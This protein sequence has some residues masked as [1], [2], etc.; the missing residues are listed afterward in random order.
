MAA[1]WRHARNLGNAGMFFGLG[2]MALTLSSA[3]YVGVTGYPCNPN[4][5]IAAAN[6]NNPCNQNNMLYRNPQPTD[7]APLLG[8]LGASTSA[9]GFI[10][11]ASSLGYQHHLLHKLDADPG[12]GVF[13][14]GTVFGVLGFVAVGV[15]YFI[16]LT[17]YLG[18]RDQALAILGTSITS[19][20]FSALGSLLYMI[21]SQRTKRAWNRL[22]TSY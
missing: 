9:L 7:P 13:A 10:L 1:R 2:G 12:R 17:D 18:P 4:D 21:D 14:A 22:P 6:P 5:P 20:F 3:I 19:T 8:Y 11:S 15:S 16:G